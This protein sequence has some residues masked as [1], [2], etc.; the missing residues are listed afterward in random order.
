[1]CPA[2]LECSK[3]H[4]IDTLPV[5][6]SLLQLE[7]YSLNVDA[8]KE[9]C[10]I[11]FSSTTTVSISHLLIPQEDPA[12]T[13][14]SSSD[15]THCR[16]VEI[17]TSSARNEDSMT[18]LTLRTEAQSECRVYC[19]TS[20]DKPDRSRIVQTSETGI[21]EASNFLLDPTTQARQLPNNRL[22]SRY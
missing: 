10:T 20:S 4:I 22:P 14:G 13:S 6:D 9:S 21:F 3:L 15:R 2:H 5:T 1:M 18:L 8:G 7:A 12:E 16:A 19:P 17:Q 11:Y